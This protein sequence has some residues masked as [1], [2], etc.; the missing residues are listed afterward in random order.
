MLQ[1]T[2]SILT[3][4][5]G[6]LT[7]HLGRFMGGARIGLDVPD[8]VQMGSPLPMAILHCHCT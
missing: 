3:Q 4:V 8:M 7:G 1:S 2:E 6:I 5:F